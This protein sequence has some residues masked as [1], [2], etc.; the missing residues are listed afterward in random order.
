MLKIKAIEKAHLSGLDSSSRVTREVASPA[1]TPLLLMAL[2]I[3]LTIKHCLETLVLCGQ[4]LVSFV[5]TLISLVFI[6]NLC[7]HSVEFEGFGGLE[8]CTQLTLGPYGGPRGVGVSYERGT[9]VSGRGSEGRKRN[10]R[11]GA[12]APTSPQIVFSNC[13]DVYHTSPDSGERQYKSR[14]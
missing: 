12:V 5:Q 7:T 6:L 11:S 9:P 10:S 2:T 14:T 1:R 4:I 13:L 8:F 3:N